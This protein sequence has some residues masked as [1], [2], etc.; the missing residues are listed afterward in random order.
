MM[1]RLCLISLCMALVISCRYDLAEATLGETAQTIARDSKELS[2]ALLKS[3]NRA[4]YRVQSIASGTTATT[5]REYVNP[6]GVVFAVA[7]NGLVHPDLHVLLGNYHDDYRKALSGT[8]RRQGR[9]GLKVMTRRMVV[10]T[11]G[12]MRNLQ[13]RA[14]LPELLPEGVSLDEIR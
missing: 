7:W 3:T 10:E 2:G 8:P 12:H 5:V 6:S 14:Y 1:L 11:W 9:R 4:S 13:G